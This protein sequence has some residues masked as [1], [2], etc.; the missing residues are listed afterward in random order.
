[1]LAY[2]TVAD[3]TIPE[4][5]AVKILGLEIALMPLHISH[6]PNVFVVRAENKYKSQTVKTFFISNSGGGGCVLCAVKIY[7]K[8]NQKKS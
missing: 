6:I 5:G 8:L 1:M 3:P 2:F 4:R 7:K